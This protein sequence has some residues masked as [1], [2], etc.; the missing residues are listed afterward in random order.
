MRASE[1]ALVRW[2][3]LRLRCRGAVGMVRRYGCMEIVRV[4]HEEGVVGWWEE[5]GAWVVRG[6]LRNPGGFLRWCL[7]RDD[8]LREVVEQTLPILGRR[9]SR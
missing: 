7:Q 5:Q 8:K 6:G 4:L 2:L 9:K 1:R 3:E